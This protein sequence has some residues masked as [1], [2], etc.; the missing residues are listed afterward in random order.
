VNAFYGTVIDFFG[1][2]AVPVPRS[3]TTRSLNGARLD[4]ATGFRDTSPFAVGRCWH[5]TDRQTA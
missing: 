2:P 1:A 4:N 5:T 3:A